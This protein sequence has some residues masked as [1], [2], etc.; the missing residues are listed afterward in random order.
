M[1]GRAAPKIVF[2]SGDTKVTTETHTVVTIPYDGTLHNLRN[3]DIVT[4]GEGKILLELVDAVVDK[5]IFSV[6]KELTDKIFVFSHNQFQDISQNHTV[7]EFRAKMLDNN[8]THVRSIE[9]T[10]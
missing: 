6:T 3:V 7:L 4:K 8:N 9:F 10:M 2:W 5:K 1:P